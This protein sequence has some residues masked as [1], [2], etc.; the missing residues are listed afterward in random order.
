MEIWVN[1]E[2]GFKKKRIL[3]LGFVIFAVIKF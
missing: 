2:K 1:R 3:F